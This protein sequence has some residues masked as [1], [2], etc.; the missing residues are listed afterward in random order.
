MSVEDEILACEEDL[1]RAQL[2]ADVDALDRIL[3]DV[4]IHEL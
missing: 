4:L 3:D 2:A 1:R